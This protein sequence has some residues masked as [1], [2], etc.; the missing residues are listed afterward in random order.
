MTDKW[1]WSLGLSLV[2]LVAATWASPRSGMMVFAGR[3]WAPATDLRVDPPGGGT[4]TYHGVTWE[5]RSLEAPIHYA[6]RAL[7]WLP[8]RPDAGVAVDFTHAKAY[9]RDL[10]VPVS[11]T[12]GGAPVDDVER[13]SASL[14]AFANSHGLNLATAGALYRRRAPRAGP[15]W[16]RLVEGYVGAGAGVAVPHVESNRPGAATGAYQLTG[17]AAQGLAGGCLSVGGRW[18]LCAEYRLG[19]ARLDETLSD[20]TRVRATVP[21]HQVLLGAGYGM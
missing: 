19:I 8:G 5:T 10:P 11:G 9:L 1:L 20:G 4:L 21:V 13:P 14:G 16:L 15:P 7:H 3:A 17:P 18:A 6:V 12:R 2:V